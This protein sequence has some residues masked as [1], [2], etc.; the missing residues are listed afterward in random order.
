MGNQR[1]SESEDVGRILVVEDERIIAADVAATLAE[2][3]YNVVGNAATGEEAI[4]KA[5]SLSPDLILMDIRLI[6]PLD[7]IEAAEAIRCEQN[8]PIVYLTSHS[9]TETLRRAKSTEPLAYLVKPF[10]IPELRCAIE[11]ALHR[12][13]IDARLRAREQWF[14]KALRSVGESIVPID[15]DENLVDE[16]VYGTSLTEGPRATALAHALGEILRRALGT[17]GPPSLRNLGSPPHMSSEE[18]N[19]AD[20]ELEG[21]VLERTAELEAANA[22]LEAFSYSVAHDLRGPL[23]GIEGISQALL[24]EHAANLGPEGVDRL[25]RVRRATQR[26][27]Q[28]IDDLLRLGRA[29]KSDFVKRPTNLSK[30]AQIVTIELEMA[31]TDRKVDFVIQDGVFVD[32]DESLLRVVLENLIGN[33]WKFTSKVERPRIEFGQFVDTAVP[34]CFVR[35]N[36]AGFDMSRA[37]SLFKAF[38]R[39]HSTRDFEGTGIGLA[40]VR[41]I[42]H[43][44]G[45]RI[46]ANSAP[47]KGATFYFTI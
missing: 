27:S 41:R 33:A 37:N 45:G 21:R 4:R 30:L 47:D 16:A 24:E 14:V 8:I 28:I 46:W 12:H 17:S 26:M 32:A 10:R 23:T 29:A 3:G 25:L 18:A 43:R 1:T 39:L 15:A 34:V 36:G 5:R 7:G 9:D 20:A 38:Q 11:I 6:G 13:E 44:H 22:E 40:I 35:D 42:V 31:H 2:L 19:R